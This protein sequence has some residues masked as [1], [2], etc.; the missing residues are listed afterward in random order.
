MH[1]SDV[2]IFKEEEAQETVLQREILRN[3]RK[4]ARMKE[5]LKRQKN[6]NMRTGNHLRPQAIQAR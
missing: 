6:G 5:L 4:E 3:I 1:N 2:V